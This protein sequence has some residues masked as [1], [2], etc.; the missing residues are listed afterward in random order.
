MEQP[1]VRTRLD[2]QLKSERLA[3]L[4]PAFARVSAMGVRYSALPGHTQE[5]ADA[6]NE[7]LSAKWRDLRGIEIAA[8]GMNSVKAS[9]EDEKLIKELQR[10]AAFRDPDMR[11]AYLAGAKASAL[12]NAAANA[13]GAAV[14]FMNMNLAAGMTGMNAPAQPSSAPAEGWRCPACGTRTTGKFCPE[15]GAKKPDPADSWKCP[16]CGTDNRGKFCTECGA[17]KPAD[18]PQYRCDKC[19]WEPADPQHPPKFCPECGDPFDGGDVVG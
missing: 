3:A 9:E 12:Q 11:D 7:V 13:A 4:Q 5:M 10:T 6:L 17:R 18:V 15:C 2:S 8:F 19:G 16:A 1:Y 14:G